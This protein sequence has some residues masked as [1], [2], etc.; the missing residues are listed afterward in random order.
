M[1]RKKGFSINDFLF[2]EKECGP[3]TE[4]FMTKTL[5]IEPCYENLIEKEKESV[6]PFGLEKLE[7]KKAEKEEIISEHDTQDNTEELKETQEAP[8]PFLASLEDLEDGTC[9]QVTQDICIIGAGSGCTLILKDEKKQRTIS[10]H[11][12]TLEKKEDGFYLTD[13]SSN[14]TCIVTK[15]KDGESLTAHRLTKG[16]PIKLRNQEIIKFANRSFRFSVMEAERC[17]K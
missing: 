10:R 9:Y 12:A 13:T 3:M 11:H 2:D 4:E 7:K 6:H 1:E 5:S 14:G 15:E 8:R 16:E 17:K